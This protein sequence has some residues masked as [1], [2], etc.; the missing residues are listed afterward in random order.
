MME[1]QDVHFIV[2]VMETQD[3]HVIMNMNTIK[4]NKNNV[5]VELTYIRIGRHTNSGG[6]LNIQSTAAYK[7]VELEL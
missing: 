4:I 3:V 5:Q 7:L 6:F 2:N 1:T